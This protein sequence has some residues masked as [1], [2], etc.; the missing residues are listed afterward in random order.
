MI[1]SFVMLMV[2]SL[3]STSESGFTYLSKDFLKDYGNILVM[4]QQNNNYINNNLTKI[5]DD[6]TW[7]SKR[8][9]L[10]INLKLEPSVPV[11]DQWTK[12]YFEIKELGSGKL[13]QNTNLTVNATITDHDGRLFKFPEQKVT[14]GKFGVSYI[15]PD[16]GQHRV[17]LQLYK[18]Y[19]ALNVAT[20]DINIPHLQPP[21]GFFERLFQP[22]PY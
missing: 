10:S 11:I 12:M 6:D 18:D 16:D 1:F 4:A 20:F 14:D 7:N 9:N 15:F 5:L 21:K 22:L 13:V 3:S 17:I 8:D 19:V 2:Y